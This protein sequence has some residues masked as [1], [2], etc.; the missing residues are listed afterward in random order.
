MISLFQSNSLFS[1][2]QRSDTY[3]RPQFQSY[4][5]ETLDVA[6]TIHVDPMPINI[7]VAPIHKPPTFATSTISLS[8]SL[9]EENGLIRK[10]LLSMRPNS[11]GWYQVVNRSV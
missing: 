10:L 1:K 3:A 8:S 6:S 9:L 11:E 5:V 2:P 4:G 7:S